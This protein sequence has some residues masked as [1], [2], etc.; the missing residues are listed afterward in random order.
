MFAL[1][2]LRIHLGTVYRIAF[3]QLGL[4]DCAWLEGRMSHS[5]GDEDVLPYIAHVRL[6]GRTAEGS[7]ENRVTNIRIQKPCARLEG[8]PRVRQGFDEHL[9][10]FGDRPLKV[11]CQIKWFGADPCRHRPQLDERYRRGVLKAIADLIYLRQILLDRV[12][13][14]DPAGFH[15]LQ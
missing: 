6:V 14:M 1:R 11:L 9:L 12:R 7:P 8:I 15:Q 3:R 2:S 10:P 5:Q 13:Q 4:D